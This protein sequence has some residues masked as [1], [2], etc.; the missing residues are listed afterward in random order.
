MIIAYPFFVLYLLVISVDGYL[1]KVIY[2]GNNIFPKMVGES[3][4]EEYFLD[5]SDYQLSK[6]L[7][8]VGKNDTKIFKTKGFNGKDYA[9]KIQLIKENQIPY[10]RNNLELMAKASLHCN[11]LNFYGCFCGDYIDSKAIEFSII[12]EL[13]NYDIIK[14]IEQHP[15]YFRDSFNMKN[16]IFQ[17]LGACVY[18]NDQNISHK[19]LSP[20]N[21]LVCGS[22]DNFFFKLAF[23]DIISNGEFIDQKYASPGIKDKSINAGIFAKSDVYSLGLI[24]MIICLCSFTNKKPNQ[25][26]VEWEQRKDCLTQIKDYYND[27]SLV[28]FMKDMLETDKENNLNLKQLQTNL[29]QYEYAKDMAFNNE[30]YSFYFSIKKVIVNQLISLIKS[31]PQI[32]PLIYFMLGSY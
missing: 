22:E 12:M 7:I 9:I 17:I 14:F 13:A 21:I 1:I 18:L 16:F 19:F 8:G 27:E 30:D 31:R 5:T 32:L 15:N 3:L 24:I 20:T 2:M 11:I 25:I 6:Y 26:L 4:I 10:L 28:K 29:K 23:P